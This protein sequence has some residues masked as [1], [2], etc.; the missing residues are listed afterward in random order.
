MQKIDIGSA[1]KDIDRHGFHIVPGF[2]NKEKCQQVIQ[3]IENYL[4]LPDKKIWHDPL[5]SDQRIFGVDKISKYSKEFY[6]DLHINKTFD[7]LVPKFKRVGLVMGAKLQAIEGNLGSGQGWHKDSAREDQFKAIL[8]LSDVN[9]K[10]GP[11]QYVDKSNRALHKMKMRFL[12]GS[13]KFQDRFDSE[14]EKEFLGKEKTTVVTGF[15]G[16]LIL[17]NTS[18]IHRGIPIIEGSRY[19]LTIYSWYHNSIPEH[20]RKLMI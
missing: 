9:E 11:F 20:I 6:E 4:V 2:W 5:F 12:C 16:T 17:S 14:K 13:G 7:V 1:V 8:Y 19:A 18:G 10:N 15:A 3:E